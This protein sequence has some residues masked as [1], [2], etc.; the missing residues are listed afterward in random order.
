MRDTEK[1]KQAKSLY[2]KKKRE[3]NKDRQKEYE[4]RFY[5]KK[6]EEYKKEGEL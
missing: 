3:N 1:I 5:L 2:L 4:R 6:F